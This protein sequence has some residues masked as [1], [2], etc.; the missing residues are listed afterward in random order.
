MDT[1]SIRHLTS[2]D[3]TCEVSPDKKSP[4]IPNST[5]N[6]KSKYRTGVLQEYVK[7]IDDLNYDLDFNNESCDITFNSETD[8]A[9]DFN[10]MPQMSLVMS[11]LS[12]KYAQTQ[13]IHMN[14]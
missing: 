4:N 7:N 9:N 11:K 13:L 8:L 2:Q 12:T 14:F 1:E 10:Y 6:P 5:L 3:D